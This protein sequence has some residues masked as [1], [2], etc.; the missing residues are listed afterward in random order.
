MPY[1]ILKKGK[2][3]I[4]KS[5]T[6]QYKHKSL[7]KAKAQKRLLEEKEGKVVQTQKVSQKVT[8]IVNAPKRRAGQARKQT[9][10]QAQ[11]I[12]AMRPVVPSNPM[13]AYYGTARPQPRSLL[14]GDEERIK[15]I[16]ENIRQLQ[17][18]FKVR[19]KKEPHLDR[20]PSRP[21]LDTDFFGKKLEDFMKVPIKE[22]PPLV[23]YD[24]TKPIF[25][26]KPTGGGIPSRERSIDSDATQPMSPEASAGRDRSELQRMTV[27]QLRQIL[28]DRGETIGKKNKAQLID[29]IMS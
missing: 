12:I 3:Y 1:Q 27:L 24:L 19:I 5:P 4:L 23:E 26:D 9:V 10:P 7:A 25:Q 15:L 14:S 21:V 8:V 20:I 22:E 17:D 29:A 2:E 6:R 11:T 13:E 18:P 28:K 16:E